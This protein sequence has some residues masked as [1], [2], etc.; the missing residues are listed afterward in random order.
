MMR[1]RETLGRFLVTTGRTDEGLAQAKISQQLDLLNQEHTS[2]YGW[3]LYLARRY[4]ESIEQHRKAIE[5]E[6]NYWPG[7]SWLGHALAQQGRWPEAIAAF[8]KAVSIE[9]VIAEPTIGL[10][11]VYAVSGKKDEAR[12]ILAELNDRSKHPFVSS[13][14]MADFYAGLGD[15]DR[16]FASLE[17]AYEERSWYMTHLKL[18]PELDPLRSDS[19]FADLVKRVGL[20]Q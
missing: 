3:E 6:P 10:G 9:H 20:P 5:L 2:V 17:R 13:Y 16:A 18:D 14:L 19:R 1:T 12:R 8:Q 7:Y 4:D 15:N 11:R